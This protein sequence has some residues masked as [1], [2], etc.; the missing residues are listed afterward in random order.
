MLFLKKCNKEKDES[1]IKT[2]IEE[3]VVECSKHSECEG[4]KFFIEDSIYHCRFYGLP[5]GWEVRE[6]AEKTPKA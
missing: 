6:D 2:T 5:M 4:C 3:V 1:I